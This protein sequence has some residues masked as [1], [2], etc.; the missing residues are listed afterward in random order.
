MQY[1]HEL[2]VA[3]DAARQAGQLI[4]RAYGEFVAIPDVPDSISTQADRD[5]QELILSVLGNAFPDDALC[6]EENTPTLLAARQYGQRVWVVDP[7]DGTRGFARK[8]GEFSVMIGFIADGQV[9]VGV[10]LEP[11]FN[12]L[13]YARRGG[14]CWYV[15]DGSAPIPCRTSPTRR[16]QSATLVQS[17]AKPGQPS[18]VVRAVHPARVLET[19]SSGIKLAMIARGEADVYVNDYRAFKDWD[20]CAGCILV[21]EAGGVISDM[22]GQPI[23]YQQTDFIQQHGLLA[24][25]TPALHAATLEL[26]AQARL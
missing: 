14:G 5:A 24:A 6:A 11:A 18:A 7:I 1:D 23:R 10:V 4:M 21:E 17:H 3:R 2:A 16:P 20:V 19:Y 25:A 8:V 13:T 9:R 15:Q 26:I 12:R 22:S